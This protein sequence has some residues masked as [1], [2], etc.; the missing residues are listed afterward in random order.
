VTLLSLTTDNPNRPIFDIRFDRRYVTIPFM[1]DSRLPE[2]SREPSQSDAAK[3]HCIRHSFVSAQSESEMILSRQTQGLLFF[4]RVQ[5]LSAHHRILHFIRFFTTTRL[6]WYGTGSHPQSR[7]NETIL[8]CSLYY[9]NRVC[10]LRG[11]SPSI[12]SSVLY[13]S[14]SEPLL[15]EVTSLS[16]KETLQQSL[17]W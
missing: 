11:A 13:H 3:E 1:T 8:T 9:I 6:C 5:Q 17:E 10:I 12:T 14:H 2:R 4:R 15:Q 7:S 16:L